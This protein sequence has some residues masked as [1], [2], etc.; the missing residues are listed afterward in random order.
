MQPV[1]W[2]AVAFVSTYYHTAFRVRGWGALPVRRPPAVLVA[3]HQ[4]EM[5]SAVIVATQSLKAL[6]VQRPIYTVSSRRMWEPGFFSERIPWLR[7]VLGT[8]NLGWLFAGIGMQPIENELHSRPFRSIA[9]ALRS[10]HGN[11][12]TASVFRDRAMARIPDAVSLDDVLSMRH[13]DA[14][15]AY[16]SLSELLEPYRSE[17]LEVTRE[18]LAADIA[19]FVGLVRSGATIFLTPEGFY[20][21]DGR[22][23]RFRGILSHLTPI[24][25][26]YL[27][28]IS[29]DPF[30]GRR[31]SM[32]Y[33]VREADPQLSIEDDIKRLRPVTTSAL[34]ASWLHERRVP[35]TAGDAVRAVEEQLAGLP[36]QAFVDPELRRNPRAMTLAA[37]DAMGRRALLLRDHDRCELAASLRHP[38]FPRTDDIVAYQAAFH[39]E[40]LDG[41]RAGTAA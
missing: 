20:T 7:P 1:R 32:L 2:L 18:Q 15:R 21:V 31:L 6:Q 16:V 28:G 35:F 34:L 40:T 25:R 3:N 4:H 17:M 27:A 33:R 36:A 14:S 38:Q 13:F 10:R 9:S 24:A 39:A 37:L 26:T 8:A 11:L 12:T 30:V 5:E 41:L 22:M 23:Q 19:H 29:Y